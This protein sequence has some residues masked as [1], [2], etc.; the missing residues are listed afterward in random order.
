MSTSIGFIGLGVMGAA[1]ARRL[2]QAGHRVTVYNRTTSRTAP[3]VEAGARAASTPRQAAQGA[4]IV[5]SVVTD[6]PDVEAVLL[7]PEGAVQGATAGALFVDMSTIAPAAARKVGAALAERQVAFLDA[8]VTGGDVGAREGTLSILVGGDAAALERARPVLEVMGRRITHCGPL[9][10]GQTMKAC[11][12][13]L[14]ALNMVGIVEALQLARRGG[15]DPRQLLEALGPGAG[16]SWA[17]DKLGPRIVAGD[18]APG[19][20]IDLI[21]KDL[22]IVQDLAAS[23]GLPLDGVTLAQAA[24]ADNQAHGEG[25]LGTQAMDRVLERKARS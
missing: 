9:G 13:I 12:Q 3:L 14:C 24:F 8:P 2:I 1:M 10:T 11:N 6:G 4:E 18:H 16:G 15:V 23:V 20:M 21:Q 22:R 5:I 17:L 19:F 25:R 7:G